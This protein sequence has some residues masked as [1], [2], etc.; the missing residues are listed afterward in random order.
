LR[1]EKAE[2]K[3]DQR[4]SKENDGRN[5]ESQPRQDGCPANRK[6]GWPKRDDCL[7]K[8]TE[9]NR[10][11]FKACQET[12]AYH[13]VTKADTEKTE[14]DPG[15]MLSIEEHQEIPKGEAAVMPVGGLRKRRRVRNLATVCH[16]KPKERTWGYCGSQKRVA[17]AGSRNVSHHA[18]VAW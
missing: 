18:K 8:V 7:Q 6:A 14:A 13:E 2:R 16:Q 1:R 9:D 17:V 10:E 11:K 15:M 5:V 3:A 12:T 4:G